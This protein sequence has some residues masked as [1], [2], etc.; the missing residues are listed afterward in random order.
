MV[1][2]KATQIEKK[3]ITDNMDLQQ[4]DLDAIVPYRNNAKKHPES[5]IT[6][7]MQSIETHGYN[8]PIALD[9]NNEIIEGH[10]R[11]EA[12]KRLNT[13]KRYQRIKI[14]RLSN[15]SETQKKSYRIAHNKLNMDTGFDLQLLN[16]ELELIED[17]G[18]DISTT[19]FTNIEVGNMRDKV[20]VAEHERNYSA[21]NK[22]I[23][24]NDIESGLDQECPKCKFKFAGKDVQ[25]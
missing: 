9:D 14:L 4:I 1:E 17:K 23:D 12:L 21:K 8:D 18:F 6:K 13:D 19:G 5:Q 2:K 20:L 10:G 24:I 11:F 15:L 16:D 7:L 25:L 22:E 3:V